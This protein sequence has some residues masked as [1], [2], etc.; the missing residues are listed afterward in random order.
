MRA[1]IWEASSASPWQ[2]WSSCRSRD[3]SAA[4]GCHLR[5]SRLVRAAFDHRQTD[6]LSS[7]SSA[8]ASAS[9]DYRVTFPRGVASDRSLAPAKTRFETGLGYMCQTPSQRRTNR[10]TDKKT[11]LFVRCVCKGRLSYGGGAEP[12]CLRRNLRGNSDQPINTR[13]LASWL[14]GKSF[15]YCYQVQMPHFKAKMHLIR[16][17]ASVRPFVSSFDTIFGTVVMKMNEPVN[18]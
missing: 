16:F 13:N 8:V 14:S 17:S 1:A 3:P 10:R 6:E 9:L 2:R 12:R 5:S 4:V 15:K 7:A 11:R 18:E